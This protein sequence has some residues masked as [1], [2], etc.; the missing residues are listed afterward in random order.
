MLCQYC[1]SRVCITHTAIS[2]ILF[3]TLNPSV[4]IPKRAC[5]HY[6][7]RT[8]TPQHLCSHLPFHRRSRP[9]VFS[10]AI[11]VHTRKWHTGKRR[12]NKCKMDS[13]QVKVQRMEE[14][15]MKISV[16]NCTGN[17]S[18]DFMIKTCQFEYAALAC[19]QVLKLISAHLQCPRHWYWRNISNEHTTTKIF[20][21]TWH[22]KMLK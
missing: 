18:V 17:A 13:K 5:V 9:P 7:S 8:H 1:S 16:E 14:P 4:S 10:Q 20:Y 22:A 6:V 2:N 12:L 11:Y 21:Q 3:L 15:F 19:A